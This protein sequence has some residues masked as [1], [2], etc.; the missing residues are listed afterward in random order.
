MV[1]GAATNTTYYYNQNAQGNYGFMDS[2][3]QMYS[4][5]NEFVNNLTTALVELR[6]YTTT[7]ALV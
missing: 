7:V 1:E 2:K 4:G 6:D 5:N 3:G